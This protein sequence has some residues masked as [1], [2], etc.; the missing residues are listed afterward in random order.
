MVRYSFPKDARVSLS[1]PQSL[2]FCKI[3]S[4]RAIC[5][6][7]AIFMWS[8]SWTKCQNI[9]ILKSWIQVFRIFCAFWLTVLHPGKH[10][11]SPEHLEYLWPL[12]QH[13]KH[14]QVCICAGLPDICHGQKFNFWTFKRAKIKSKLQKKGFNFAVF[15]NNF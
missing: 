5:Q 10:G 6:N 15:N 8:H 3:R 7:W 2:G 9:S 13:K 14:R 12:R 4:V 11:G 1:C